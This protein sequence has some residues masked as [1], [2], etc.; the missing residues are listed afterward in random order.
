MALGRSVWPDIEQIFCDRSI[1]QHVECGGF[2]TDSLM[3]V[4]IFI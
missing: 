4:Q 1:P 2:K 3:L